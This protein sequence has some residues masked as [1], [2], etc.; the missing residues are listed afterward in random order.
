M[1][2]GMGI[3]GEPGVK[4]EALDRRRDGRPHGPKPSLPICRR[5]WRPR[6]GDG[7]RAGATPPEELYILYRQVHDC[8]SG[9][10]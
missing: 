6:G 4:R 9:A 1:E 8:L 10:A 7:Q 3:H 2:I 5:R